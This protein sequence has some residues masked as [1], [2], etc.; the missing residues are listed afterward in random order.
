MRCSLKTE[1][2]RPGG[3]RERRQSLAAAGTRGRPADYSSEAEMGMLARGRL[4]NA[5]D[6]RLAAAR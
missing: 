4:P 1:G 6:S 2:D 3:P 5:S